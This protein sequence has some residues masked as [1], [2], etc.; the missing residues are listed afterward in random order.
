[1]AASAESAALDKLYAA[2]TNL[3]GVSAKLSKEGVDEF[4]EVPAGHIARAPAALWGLRRARAKTGQR[5]GVPARTRGVPGAPPPAVPTRYAPS[6][7]CS[8]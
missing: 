6:P 5:A 8:C 7:L 2:S 3:V 1:M 4:A